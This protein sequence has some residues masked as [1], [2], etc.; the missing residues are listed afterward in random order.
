MC[1]NYSQTKLSQLEDF[2]KIHGFSFCECMCHQIYITYIHY[3]CNII[4]VLRKILEYHTDSISG[5]NIG[6]VK[7]ESSV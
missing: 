6:T 2:I 7:V 5:A 3:I 4:N 1:S